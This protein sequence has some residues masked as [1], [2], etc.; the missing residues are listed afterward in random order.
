MADTSI[1]ARA[2]G[3]NAMR[4]ASR[5]ALREAAELRQY[6]T[7]TLGGELF[8][9]PIECIREIIEF[10]GLTEVPM[11][12][13]FLR[14]VINLRGSV[15]PV[16][17]LSVRFAR[18]VTQIGRRTCIVI[19][20]VEQDNAMQA[21]GVIVDAVNEVLSIDPATI[22]PRPSFGSRIRADFITGIFRHAERFVIALDVQQVLSVD[23]MSAL[24]DIADDE[25]GAN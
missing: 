25:P 9:M 15:V 22:E 17:D 8:A 23:E 2:A 18:D 7:F 1:Q 6:L 19:L 24:A 5:T 11:M 4:A 21:L 13:P 12:P 10:G 16:V 3:S 14:G 20:E